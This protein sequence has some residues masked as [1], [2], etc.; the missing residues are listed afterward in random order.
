L[1]AAAA[2]AL[3]G[4]A[5]LMVAV[6]LAGCSHRTGAEVPCARYAAPAGSDAGAGTAQ[7]P[8][9]TPQRLAEALAPGDTGCLRAGTYRGRGRNGLVLRL[10]RGGRRGAPIRLRGAPGEQA[11]LAGPVYVAPGARDVVLSDLTVDD[12]TTFAATGQI[13]IQV[14]AADTT[15]ERLRITTRGRKTCVILGYDG[16]GGAPAIDTTI[17]DSDLVDCGNPA[18]AMH[19]H[20]IY[21]DAVR[22]ALIEGNLIRGASGWAVHLY[23]DARGVVVRDNVLLG[24]GG[25]VIF[26]GNARLASAS[27]LVEANV[28]AGSRIVP[29]I[30]S[31]WDG[32]VG[33]GNVARRNCLQDDL[34]EAE[35]VAAR[36]NVLAGPS[37]VAPRLGDYRPA[38]G[39]PCGLAWIPGVVR[40]AL[41]P[42]GG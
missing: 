13:A 7:V 11:I 39:S 8:F 32:P 5:V 28:I 26:A 35:G 22:G 42:D 23:P 6:A 29:D 34:A 27:D 31:S 19:D 41:R 4:S 12:P 17:R 25:G 14:L 21:A 18:A 36:G 3:R 16:P 9:R 33:R 37:F 10:V 20:A 1:R 2:E 40:P 30:V 24:N 38:A 15:L